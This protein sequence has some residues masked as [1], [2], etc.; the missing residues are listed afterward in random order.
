MYVKKI[1]P[2][3]PVA[4]MPREAL[5]LGFDFWF[6]PLQMSISACPY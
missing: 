4:Q 1:V 6:Q 2:M 5:W 3:C